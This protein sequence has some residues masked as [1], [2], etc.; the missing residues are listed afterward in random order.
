MHLDE[1]AIGEDYYLGVSCFNRAGNPRGASEDQ[2]FQKKGLHAY[3][4]IFI[5]KR[6][7][8]SLHVVPPLYDIW[9]FPLTTNGVHGWSPDLWIRPLLHKIISEGFNKWKS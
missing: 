8:T 2:G 3:R 6:L 4:Q 9:G 5:N 7:C 1:R